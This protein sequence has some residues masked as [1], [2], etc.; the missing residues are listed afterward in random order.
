MPFCIHAQEPW[1]QKTDML[2]PNVA[3]GANVVDGNIYVIGGGLSPWYSYSS[4][5]VCDPATDTWE[6]LEAPMPTAR[7]G[8]ATSVVNGIIYAIGESVGKEGNLYPGLKTVEAFDPAT[9]TWTTKA[10]MSIAMTPFSS[11]VVD[12]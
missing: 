9:G 12:D 6:D 1:T 3:F 5:E 7:F 2:K 10:D 4:V 11:S 8:L